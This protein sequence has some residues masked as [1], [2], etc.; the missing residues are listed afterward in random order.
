[1]PDGAF[2]KFANNDKVY[3]IE[4]AVDL[5]RVGVDVKLVPNL[6]AALARGDAVDL[7]P[8]VRVRHSPTVILGV[9][10]GRNGLARPVLETEEVQA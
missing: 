6:R 10:K 3:A 9:A 8:S 2:L 4:G 1:M 5:G 7:T